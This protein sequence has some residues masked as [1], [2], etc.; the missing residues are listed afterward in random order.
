MI[1]FYR[2]SNQSS[3]VRIYSYHSHPCR[4]SRIYSCLGILKNYTV[5]RRYLQE[6]GGFKVNFRVWFSV[7]HHLTIQSIQKETG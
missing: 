2:L 3:P 7:F 5:F 1:G 4:N 6:F